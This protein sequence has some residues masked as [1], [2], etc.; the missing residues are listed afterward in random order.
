MEVSIA[1]A[2]SFIE[3]MHSSKWLISHFAHCF[4]ATW[5]MQAE[6]ELWGGNEVPRAS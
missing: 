2:N 1:E 4:T 5:C 3:Q 6:Q